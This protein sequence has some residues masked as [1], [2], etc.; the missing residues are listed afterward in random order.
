MTGTS[1]APRVRPAVRRLAIAACVVLFPLATWSLWDYIELRRLTAEIES[2]Q[3]KGEPVSERQTVAVHPSASDDATAGSYYLAGAALALPLHPY[4]APVREW[5]AASQPDRTQ[6][7]TL[8]EPLNALLENSQD[9]LALADKAAGMP[10][11]GFPPG[12][13]FNYRTAGLSSLALTISAR[14]LAESLAGRGENAATSVISGI[15][16]RRTLQQWR[17]GLDVPAVLSLSTPSAEALGRMQ[18]ALEKE[19]DADAALHVVLADRARF[20]DTV[21]RRYYGTDPIAPRSYRLPLRSV[22]ESVARPMFTHK[23]VRVLRV[24]RE[25]VEAARVPWPGKVRSS[26]AVLDKYRGERG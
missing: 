25:M 8:A 5:L 7:K 16:I 15:R 1:P 19:D 14:T 2:I 24:W 21:W 4:V 3:A 26:Q 6:I 12:T 10:F 11:V 17:D 9:A 13:E 22:G 20:I 18:D 23:V